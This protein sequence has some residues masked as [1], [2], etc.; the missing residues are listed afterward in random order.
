MNRIAIAFRCFFS[1]L[2]RGELPPSVLRAL[3]LP[4]RG[5]A[6]KPAAPAKPA[7]ASAA[8]ASPAPAAARASD[9]AL[10]ILGIMQREGRLIDFLMEDIASYSDEQIGAA[11]RDIHGQSRDALARIVTLEPVIDGVEGTFAKAPSKN[12]S[13][14]RFVGKVPA[15]LPEGGTLRHKGWRATK[16][17]L[18]A[19]PA[20]QD[21][22]IIAPAE[23]EI[24]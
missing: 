11:V 3:R 17:N 18:P 8:A 9:G 5:A 21:A 6:S 12:P 7:A 4:P 1:V 14:V 20:G 16:V 10:Q 24:E 15:K 13:V 2:F 23:I 19:L 22:A